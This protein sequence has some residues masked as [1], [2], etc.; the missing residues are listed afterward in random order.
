[1]QQDQLMDERISAPEQPS[2]RYFPAEHK[3]V[4]LAAVLMMII[5]WGGLIQ[6][7]TATRPRIGG[8]IWFFFILLQ[9]AVTG[10]AIPCFLLLNMRQAL[11]GGEAPPSAVIVRRGVWA[12]ILVVSCAWLLIPRALSFPIVIALILLVAAFEVFLRNRETA[13]ER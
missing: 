1:M 2:G 3:G 10:T 6:L 11:D 13:H 7:V 12:G 5:G 4:L 9:F 8:E